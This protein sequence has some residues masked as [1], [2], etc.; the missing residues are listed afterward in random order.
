MQA[1]DTER[2][3]VDSPRHLV[4]VLAG[5]DAGVAIDAA[6]GVAKE[7]HPRHRLLL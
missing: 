4:L 6:V 2:S 3:P 7:F 1:I 5:C